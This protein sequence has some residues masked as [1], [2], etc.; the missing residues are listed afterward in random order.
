MPKK[1]SQP[2]ERHHVHLYKGDWED[3]NELFG[4]SIGA[5]AAVREIV[6]KAIRKI[7]DKKAQQARNVDV[8]L[9]EIAEELN[10]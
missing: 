7:K 6:H 5:G 8:N 10:G 9:D 1:L 2:S 4:D 3:L